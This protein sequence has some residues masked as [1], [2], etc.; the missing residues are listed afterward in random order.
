MGVGQPL[1]IAICGAG[2][3][4]AIVTHL[5]RDEP[6]VE[7]VCL[8]QVA[9]DDHSHAGTGLNVGPNALKILGQAD[10]ALAEALRAPG[11]SLP[12]RHWRTT[13]T[14]GTELM[15][16][17]LA[18]VADNDGMRIR[19]SE[20]YRQ[21][22]APV[23]DRILFNREV[24]RMG[25]QGGEAGARI[26]ID[27]RNRADGEEG[28]LTDVDLLIGGDGRY[29]MV[30]EQFLGQPEPDHLGVVIYRLL[31]PD[32]ADG[33]I[34]DYA[35]WF[36][37]PNR[38]LAFR[39]PGE[40]IYIAGAF[41]IPA[42]APISEDAKSAEAL[43]LLYSPAGAPPSESAAF[44]IDAICTHVDAI[45]W[46]RVQ[47]IPP[48]FADERG[49]VLLLGDASHAMVP[50]L[51]QGATMAVEDACLY[52]D[53]IRTAVRQARGRP[54]D[55]PALTAR[56]AR[57]REA[58]VRFVMAFSREA[59][60]TML[61]GSDPVRDSRAKMEVPFLEKL[62]RVYMGTPELE[63]LGEPMGIGGERITG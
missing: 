17:P 59:S 62:R 16:L 55:V 12:W 9:P 61:P 24:L 5:L 40:A 36:N 21:L 37:G 60:D 27:Y 14:D 33:L 8:E 11:V 49:R 58:R 38:L 52:A 25:Y 47:D 22:R 35:Q 2:V 6:G 1:R 44:L 15:D 3:G 23:M 48:A 43:R 20:L 18:R 54:V 10:P 30:R 34:D 46:A 57:R 31:V 26:S 28:R 41:P 42:G 7:V 63:S 51:G 19:W 45:H 50:T 13:L 29:S 39:V 32:T 56:V 4:G 53:C